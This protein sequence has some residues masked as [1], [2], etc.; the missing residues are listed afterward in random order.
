MGA[1]YLLRY[2]R[3]D[4]INVTVFGVIFLVVSATPFFIEVDRSLQ[5]AGGV[6]ICCALFA[7]YIGRH[8]LTPLSEH[9]VQALRRYG[10]LPE[11]LESLQRDWESESALKV[12]KAC[13]G[14][15][16]LAVRGI[17]IQV[18]RVDEIT[19]VELQ[20]TKRTVNGIPAGSTWQLLVTR[21]DGGTEVVHTPQEVGALLLRSALL[22]RIARA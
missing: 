3:N 4:C 7:L 2:V 18:F 14:E 1:N 15:T 19:A 16:W 9:T 10:P 11:V 21:R 13:L 6:G 5:F 12:G 8:A 17:G 22:S 20:E